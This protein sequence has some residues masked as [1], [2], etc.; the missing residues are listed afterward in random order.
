[1]SGESAELL[2]CFRDNAP[3][4]AESPRCQHPSG[5]CPFRDF[6]LIFQAERAGT[7]A[8]LDEDP[9]GPR[10]STPKS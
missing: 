8:C 7:I 4:R 5:F 2:Y 1:M 9:W 6:C 3:V 10:R